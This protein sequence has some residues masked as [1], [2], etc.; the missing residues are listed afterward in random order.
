MSRKTT[1]Y[2]LLFSIKGSAMSYLKSRG[3]PPKYVYLSRVLATIL[4][5]RYMDNSYEGYALDAIDYGEFLIKIHVVPSY[6]GH[7]F[8]CVGD[9]RDYRDA[10]AEHM[11]LKETDS[12]HKTNEKYEG[13]SSSS[14][15]NVIDIFRKR[16]GG[17]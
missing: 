8:N 16:Q 4:T 6:L 15:N 5:G 9:Q 11:L 12:I 2:K 13:N 14:V 10:I 3:R 17:I 1:H 7:D